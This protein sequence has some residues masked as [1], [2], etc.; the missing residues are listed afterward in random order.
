MNLP[1]QRFIRITDGVSA[2]LA[3]SFLCSESFAVAAHTGFEIGRCIENRLGRIAGERSS[4]QPSQRDGS[5]RLRVTVTDE[6]GI[7]VLAAKL[8][9]VEAGRGRIVRA[10][11]EAGQGE[12]TGL[13]A[14]EYQLRIEKPGFYVTELKI[15]S[16][17]ES[18]QVTLY[19]QQEFTETVNVYESPAGI[20][21]E[22]TEKSAV[23]TSREILSLP[24]PSTHDVRNALPFFPEI[25]QDAVGRVHV[26]GSD[27][28]QVQS[29]LDGFNIMHP[30]TGLLE[31]HVSTDAI[32]SIELQTSRYS[33]QY[34]QGSSG[35]LELATGMGDDRYRF[36]ATNFIPG[37]QT[38]KGLHVNNWTP[39]WTISGPIRRGRAWFY[40]AGDG[41]YVQNVVDELPVGA[42]R[43]RAWRWSGLTKS[44]IN[45]N[46]RN[47]LTATFLVNRFRSKHDGLSL[48]TPLEATVDR[49]NSAYLLALKGQTYRSNGLFAEFG[50]GISWYRDDEAPQ[51]DSPYRLSPEGAS[52]NFFRQSADRAR[53]AQVIANL[54][55]PTIDWAGR[56]EFKTGVEL[57]SIAYERTVMRRPIIVVRADGTLARTSAFAG[58]GL[59]SKDNF[60]R[61]A[62]L[63]DRWSITRRLTAELGV[64][65]DRDSIIHQLTFSPRIAFAYALG[66][67]GKTKLSFGVGDF[68]DATNLALVTR[69]LEGERTDV[70]YRRDGSVRTVVSS[71]SVGE[72]ILKAPRFLNWSAGIER[73]LPA[74][75]YL[76]VE[77]IARRGRDQLVYVQRDL[78]QSRVAF[79]LTND[80]RDRFAGLQVVLRRT[81]KNGYPLFA[82]YSYMR[83]RSNAVFDFDIDNPVFSQQA[84]GPLPWE[85]PHRF[86]LW[87]VAPLRKS[88]DLAYS[89]D[90][91]TG[92]PYSFINQEQQVVGAP[93]AHRLPD[94]FSLNAHV[95]WRFD[96]LKY[97][98]ALRV[99]MNNITGRRNPTVINSNI[100]SP[101]FMEF[102]GT[103]HRVLTSRIRFLGRK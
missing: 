88:F 90:W 56:H 45:L 3:L 76:T 5:R 101:H 87:G 72:P 94:Y 102:S 50:F 86:L 19:H 70:F 9:L 16:D 47:I 42:D 71:F 22:R 39:R 67:N 64:R 29:N 75:F 13:E 95:E 26:N 80:R 73:E 23:L 10:T 63:Q 100:D 28:Y 84:S 14:K 61:G 82:S 97:R 46:E 21:A 85:V 33:V 96:L 1:G 54:T 98:L 93:N 7:P 51:G 52:G 20:Q 83:A 59:L 60:A 34:G 6:N 32:R 38:N 8:S 65:L 62:F 35:V 25:L 57:N 99:G 55:L 17:T 103:Q 2:L 89:A 92:F 48:L 81:F 53:R 40:E 37:V 15:A 4:V 58:G 24:Y 79:A 11:D 36:S 44:Q 77:F 69:P 49:R 91:H 68:R 66:E 12:F 78:A 74:S 30:V 27:A 41:E 43:A 18:V 31:M